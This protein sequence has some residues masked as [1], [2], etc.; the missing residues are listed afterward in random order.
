MSKHA[1]VEDERPRQRH[2]L[3]LAARELPRVAPFVAGQRDDIEHAGHALG[4]A[5]LRHLAHA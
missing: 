3:L 5:R 2:A 4:D 1:R